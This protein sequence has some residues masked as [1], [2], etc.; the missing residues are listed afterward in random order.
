MRD[1]GDMQKTE[2][3]PTF[4]IMVSLE[5]EE[6]GAKIRRALNMSYGVHLW[7]MKRI[8]EKWAKT[9]EVPRFSELSPELTQYISEYTDRNSEVPAQRYALN[10]AVHKAVSRFH[11]EVRVVGEGI[12]EDGTERTVHLPKDEP[13]GPYVQLDIQARSIW[14][15]YI[16][17]Y[18][19]VST[20]YGMVFLE[21]DWREVLEQQAEY[22]GVSM[23]LLPYLWH[24]ATIVEGSYKG[25]DWQIR[26]NFHHPKSSTGKKKIRRKRQ[27]QDNGST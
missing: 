3:E 6:M 17:Q 22:L 15:K 25:E 24:S 20:A 9:L 14:R 12:T 7:A 11:Q 2:K 26:F 21:G 13:R 1:N 27:W 8:K 18:G 23:Q 19:Q 16:E 10:L 5:S 4:W